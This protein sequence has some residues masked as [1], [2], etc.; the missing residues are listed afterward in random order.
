MTLFP[1]LASC[2]GTQP[3]AQQAAPP[4]V[5]LFSVEA[6]DHPWPAEYQAQTQGSRAVEVR[7]RVEGIIKKRM[8]TEGDFVKAGQLL[9]TLEP[10]QYEAQMQEA[11]AQY[12]N[13]KR[14]WDRVR[15]LYA[16]NAV[17]QKDRDSARA[18]CD[19][20]RA[21]LRQARI[22]LDYCQVT[23]PVSGFTGKEQVTPGN[24]VSNN[25]LLTYVNQTDPLYVNFSLAGPEYLRRQQM[26]R[27]GQLR[28]PEN[29]RY[30]A[31]IRLVDGS[32]Y[33]VAGEVTFIDTQ[34]ESST[35]VIKARAEFPNVSDTVMPGQ[36]VRLLMDGD[37]LVNAI[38]IPQKC[39]LLTQ[40]GTLVM[41]VDDKNV[42]SVRPVKLGPSIGTSY[43]VEAGLQSG[44]RIIEEGLVKARPG[45][46]VS[47]AP[48]AAPQTAPAAGK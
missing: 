20:A 3:Q 1:L 11:A 9:F 8:Y 47:T 30:A 15:Q 27:Q 13:A 46:P 4:L 17:S 25:S 18:A 26:A 6:G 33:P 21:A 14:E 42:V 32:M 29:R 40:Q 12:D 45:Q 48:A 24:L 41:V 23:A 10:D 2:D 16:K 31:R 19:S 43:L 22:N 36:Y 35:G 34:V 39:V 38:L 5:K 7:A 28:M 44:E 37:V